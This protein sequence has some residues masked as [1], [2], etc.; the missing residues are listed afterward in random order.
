MRGRVF[1]IV[2]A[3]IGLVVLIGVVAFFVAAHPYRIPASSME[4][5]FHCAKPNPGCEAA[6]EDRVIVLKFI[7][8]GRGDIVAFKV[9]AQQCG[10][11]GTVAYIKRV[12]GLG[13]ETVSERNGVVSIDGKVLA[14][15]YI[16]AGRRDH[17]P[18]H[19]WRVPQGSVFLVGDNRAESCDS[20]VFGAIP[21][22]D[23]VGKVVFRYW[24]PD[25]IG[26][27]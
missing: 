21:K 17:E 6:Y 4:P 12:I 7:A 11:A 3:A 23:V 5:T 13:G 26:F 2:G 10:I 9:S 16:A 24:P 15:P 22:H 8:W 1:G 18:P 19:S 27:P 14:E 25:R 20:R